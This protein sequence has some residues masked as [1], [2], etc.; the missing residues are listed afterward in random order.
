MSDNVID[1]GAFRVSRNGPKRS[2]DRND[3]RCPHGQIELDDQGQI[4]RC[5]QCGETLSAYWALGMLAKVF[6]DEWEKL[7]MAQDRATAAR[8]IQ[9]HLVA[10]KSLEKVWRSRSMVPCCPHCDRGILAE[11]M[12]RP[13]Q[14]RREFEIKRRQDGAPSNHPGLTKE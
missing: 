1:I 4:V 3:K 2:Y 14:T 5:T 6:N 10:A 8:E 7:K 9:L 13:A 11:D 12:L